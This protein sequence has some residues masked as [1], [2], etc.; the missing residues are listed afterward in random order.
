MSGKSEEISASSGLSPKFPSCERNGVDQGV[1]NV[2][3]H[4]DLI[5]HLTIFSQSNGQVANLQ[6]GVARVTSNNE[7]VNGQG[8]K[9]DIAHQYDR[10][11][12]LQQWLFKK[13]RF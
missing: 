3:V 8:R 11:A 12:I 2:L 10:N 4:S 13:V 1:H 6:A 5:P 9:V 7:I